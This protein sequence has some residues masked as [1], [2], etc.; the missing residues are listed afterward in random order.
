MTKLSLF[1][2]AW[3]GL[4]GGADVDMP[5]SYRGQPVRPGCAEFLVPSFFVVLTWFQKM[6]YGM[7]Q[8][9]HNHRILTEE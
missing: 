2:L 8:T 6:Y 4:L 1:A 9:F 3:A 7:C 5:A